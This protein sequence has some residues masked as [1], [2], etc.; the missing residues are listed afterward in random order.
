MSDDMQAEWR[1][2]VIRKLEIL[3]SKVD[4]IQFGYD[5]RL[6]RLESNW[7]KVIGVIATINVV[8]CTA[9]WWFTRSA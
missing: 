9:M 2:L 3:D 4:R 7:A 1:A 6:R 8:V 5:N